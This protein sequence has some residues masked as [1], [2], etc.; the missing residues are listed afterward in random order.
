MTCGHDVRRAVRRPIR[1]RGTSRAAG[2][3]A[4]ATAGSA[5]TTDAGRRAVGLGRSTA[6]DGVRGLPAVLAAWHP[7]GI[8]FRRGLLRQG[9]LEP[10]AA[11]RG[12]G[13]DRHR[14]GVCRAPATG[15]VADRGRGGSVR[16]HRGGLAGGWRD[17]RHPVRARARPGRPPAH[18]VYPARLRRRPAA[19]LRRP[20]VRAEPHLDARHLPDGVRARRLRLPAGRPG[21]GP[22]PA[23]P[24]RRRRGAAATSKRRRS[25]PGT[26]LVAHRGRALSRCRAGHQVEFGVLPR[27][28]RP[29]GLRVGRGRSPYGGSAATVY[30]GAAPRPAL[31]RRRPGRSAGRGLPTGLVGM[32]RHLER[33][34]PALGRGPERRVRLRA[35]G[36]A[37]LVALPRRDT[38]FPHHPDRRA[39]LPVA[40]DRLAA[41]GPPGAVLLHLTEVR[42]AGL[43][44]RRR[45]RPRGHRP[46]HA[47]DL[48]DL[49]RRAGGNAVALGGAPRLARGRGAH[50]GDGRHLAVVS[51][52]PAPPHDVPVLRL[53]GTAVP[54]A[55][56]HLGRRP[57]AGSRGSG[58]PPTL[59]RRRRRRGVRRP[60]RGQLLWAAAHPGRDSH[61]VHVLARPDVVR[62]LDLTI[63][64]ERSASQPAS[65]AVCKST[66]ERSRQAAR[67][68]TT[69]LDHRGGVVAQ[70]A[71]EPAVPQAVL[72]RPGRAPVVK[73]ADWQRSGQVVALRDV[74]AV[75][76]QGSHHRGRPDPLGDHGQPEV[77]AKL[78]Q[79]VH[80]HGLAAVLGHGRDERAVDL[81]LGDW[82][83]AELR[84]AG[85][86]GTEIVDGEPDSEAAQSGEQVQGAPRFSDDGR[87]GDLQY[88]PRRGYA[89]LVQ[90]CPDLVKQVLV[91]QVAAGDVDRNRHRPP[92]VD[93]ESSLSECGVE[94]VV[95]ERS[96]QTSALGQWDEVIRWQQPTLGMLPPDQRLHTGDLTGR[97][98][99]LGLIMQNQLSTGHPATELAQHRQPL[100]AGAFIVH[101]VRRDTEV[102]LLGGVHRAVGLLEQGGSAMYAAKQQHLGV[103]PYSVDD[104]SSSPQRL[105][106]LGELRRGMSRGEL[107]LHYQPKVS[108]STGEVTGVE[109]L[110]RWQHPERGLLPPDDFIPLAER[111]GL[112]G[113]LTD[114]VLDA[115]FAQA[116]LWI[117]V[118][119][120]MTIAVNVSGRNLLD[121]HLLD[122]VRAAL[123]QHGV[124]ASR[125]VLEVTETAIIAEPRRTLD[126][127]TRLSGLGVR[128]SIDDF[129]AGY[130]S[131]AQLSTL[132]VTELKIDRSF[133]SAMTEHRSQAMIV[134]SLIELGHNLGLTMVAEGVETAAVMA[135]LRADGCDVAQGY[136]LTRP[137]P[138]G[139]FDDWC[140]TW[141]GQDSLGDR[142][143]DRRLSD[144]AATVVQQRRGTPGRLPRPLAG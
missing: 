92:D 90:S 89:V 6:G 43:R 63:P 61:P 28:L 60:G 79:T 25:A 130:T 38:A 107:V 95:G 113:P 104:E 66:G 54:R 67:R 131:L 134:H 74:A 42:R 10:V 29:A 85:V 71:V 112:I 143:L 46:R 123:D 36:A 12:A 142:R 30:R 114:Y 87:F 39:P 22:R 80:D 127:L 128:L 40:P 32:V 91:Q 82:Q 48:V 34:G 117:D 7:P 47:G 55:R 135:A 18:P 45:L 2:A 51:R 53:A 14:A 86:S 138:I 81:E 57:G 93:P 97:Q 110:V 23:R 100:R 129:G 137:L 116:R 75:R 124:P 11:W 72:A 84:E 69:L 17:G 9:R 31:A 144:H 133:V 13:R 119:R 16:Q 111:T 1:R 52:R 94:D 141:S 27:W 33:L 99:D 3:G 24:H 83:C 126:L 139:A 78:D 50:R 64:T 109:A 125:L 70:P 5:G 44:E 106:M 122:Q 8:H 73:R 4:S 35:G 102:L 98:A 68:T 56:P 121:E 58:A 49:D 41:A 65:G 20:G 62:H 96:D 108:L 21:P 59:V 77:V 132:P 136:Y 140:A 120:P 19:R 15:K 88:Q 37:I 101:A 26:S 103:A 115:A 105:A 118:G 76:S